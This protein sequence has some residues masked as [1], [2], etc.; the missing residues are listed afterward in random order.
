[1]ALAWVLSDETFGLSVAAA[2]RGEPDLVRYKAALDAQLLAGWIIGTLVGVVVGDRVDPNA[3]GAEV[4]FAL[5]F[6]GLAAPL[7]RRW[8]DVAVG[9]L[10]VGAVL[11]AAEF[12]P[13]AWQITAAAGVAAAIGTVLPDD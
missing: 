3:W 2:D 6:I 13:S 10:A 5:L 1:M 4:F 7:V 12:L 8:S 9:G 11:L